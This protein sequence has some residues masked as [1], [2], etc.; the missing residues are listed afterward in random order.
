[1]GADAVRRS[2]LIGIMFGVLLWL[3]LPELALANDCPVEDMRDCFGTA[4]AATTAA[5]ALTVLAVIISMIL[6]AMPI[7]GTAKGLVE[8]IT[9]RD[10]VTDQELAWW[11]RVLGVV[12]FVG[13]ATTVGTVAAKTARAANTVGRTM[14]EAHNAALFAKYLD[15]LRTAERAEDIIESL[16]NTGCL[17]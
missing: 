14:G 8:F 13:A 2:L 12:P 3:I 11:E 17:V 4:Q 6:N 7:I 9:G 5:V 15:A 16:R 10:L 1:M